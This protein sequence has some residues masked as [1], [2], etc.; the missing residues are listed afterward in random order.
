MPQRLFLFTA[1]SENLGDKS[2]HES[3]IEVFGVPLSVPHLDMQAQGKRG[4]FG[5][6]HMVPSWRKCTESEG[7]KDEKLKGEG[8]KGVNDS[9]GDTLSTHFASRY[10]YSYLPVGWKFLQQTFGF[11]IKKIR[12]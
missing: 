2:E 1:N 9:R 7:A 10:K 11:D 6:F 4:T 12:Q 8:V 5:I 3:Y